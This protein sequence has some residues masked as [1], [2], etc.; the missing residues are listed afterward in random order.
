M[1]D[2]HA[3]VDVRLDDRREA[4]LIL[5]ATSHDVFRTDSLAVRVEQ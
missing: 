2:L 3:H 1:Q 5:L 4:M